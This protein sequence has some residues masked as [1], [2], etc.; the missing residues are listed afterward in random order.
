MQL[1]PW[2]TDAVMIVAATPEQAKIIPGFPLIDQIACRDCMTSLI[3]SRRTY[4]AACREAKR[5]GIHVQ[6][7]CFEC[8]A[9]YDASTHRPVD[10]R[11][12]IN[13]FASN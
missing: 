9:K 8:A 4:D 12:R 6:Y 3:G 13:Q 10:H 11:K 1:K 7:F 2:P 5:Q